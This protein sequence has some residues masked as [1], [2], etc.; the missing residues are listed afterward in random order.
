MDEISLLRAEGNYTRVF[1]A[2]NH[3][4][5][6]RSLGQIELRLDPALFFRANRSE[7]I[8]LRRVTSI[9]PEGGGYVVSLR[10]G[11]DVAVSRRQAKVLRDLLAL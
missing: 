3:P 9:S 7:I 11:A 6:P 5:I 10:D 8:N 2:G 4:M 1:F